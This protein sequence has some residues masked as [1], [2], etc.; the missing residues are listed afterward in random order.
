MLVFNI[1]IVRGDKE[2][3]FS[4]VLPEQIWKEEIRRFMEEFTLNLKD[5]GDVRLREI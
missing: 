4:K 3:S 2:K 5:F 1:A